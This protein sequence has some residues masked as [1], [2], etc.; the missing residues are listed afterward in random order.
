MKHPLVSIIVVNWNGK[1]HLKECFASLRRLSYGNFEVIMADNAST[2]GS[3]EYV[4]RNFPRVIIVQCKSNLGFTGG[5]NAAARKAKGKYLFFLNNDTRVH[6]ACIAEM[7]RSA[8][9]D[10]SIGACACRIMSYDGKT[11]IS[12]GHSCDVF[13]YPTGG[14]P[15]FFAQGAALFIRRDLFVRLN[16]FDDTYFIFNEDLDI[17]WRVQLLGYK[18]KVVPS[19][20]IYHKEGATVLGGKSGERVHHTSLQRRYLGERNAIRT[21]LKNYGAGMLILVMPLYLAMN[22]GEMLL[23]A[24][25]GNIRVARDAYLKAITWNAENLA[26]TLTERK[27]IQSNRK[28]SDMEIL[29]RMVHE[30][31]KMEV[32][33]KVGLPKFK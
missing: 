24:L 13:A 28:I 4:R 30:C 27:K 23:F 12:L 6:P 14:G 18:I 33:K 26:D 10:A 8:E 1:Q 22:A 32:L 11:E 29:R 5:N 19:A 9:R 16:G 7:V 3:S 25:T 15:V 17:C 2:D 31:T 21:L 20:V